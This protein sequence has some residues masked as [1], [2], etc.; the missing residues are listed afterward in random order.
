MT[1]LGGGRAD[2]LS[3]L[4]LASEVGRCDLVGELSVLLGVLLLVFR[5][6]LSGELHSR[7]PQL[8]YLLEVWTYLWPHAWRHLGCPR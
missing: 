8:N 4:L 3:A 1:P 2:L 5:G 6:L 7:L